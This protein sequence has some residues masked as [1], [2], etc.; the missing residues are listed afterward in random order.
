MANVPLTKCWQRVP[1]HGSVVLNLSWKYFD[2]CAFIQPPSLPSPFRLD[3]PTS[4]SNIVSHTPGA[5][6]DYRSAALPDD[7]TCSTSST[8]V[9]QIRFCG[10]RMS[11][12]LSVCLWCCPLGGATPN[13]NQSPPGESPSFVYLLVVLLS[14]PLP[15]YFH[16]DSE[17]CLLLPFRMIFAGVTN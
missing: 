17:S 9:F 16:A 6:V 15:V 12:R 4:S 8:Y 2:C 11:V 10:F 14:F 7:S 1:L 5:F 3:S 13:R